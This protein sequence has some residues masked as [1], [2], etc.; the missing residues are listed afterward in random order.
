MWRAQTS[1]PAVVRLLTRLA[2]EAVHVLGLL[3]PY[4]LHD[5]A[6]AIAAVSVCLPGD[7][8]TAHVL[9]H[10]VVTSPSVLTMSAG[11]RP[12]AQKDATVARTRA[13]VLPVLVALLGDADSG[14]CPV[15]LD[16]CMQCGVA[17]P[18]ADAHVCPTPHTRAAVVA[19]S[20]ALGERLPAHVDSLRLVRFDRASTK[21]PLA[22][23]WAYTTL[24]HAVSVT[25]SRHV[26]G[27]SQELVRAGSS[28]SLPRGAA[29]SLTR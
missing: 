19:H 2:A 10:K 1:D 24:H 23:H 13:A 28:C 25:A 20:R 21:L 6:A 3:R 29:A 4:S 17:W 12:G 5:A 27:D 14:T 9:L 8:A 22:T 16:A 7:E 11:G 26:A 18:R 15:L